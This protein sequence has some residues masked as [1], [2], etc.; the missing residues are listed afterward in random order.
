[1]SPRTPYMGWRDAK[2][3]TRVAILTL[4]DLF[5]SPQKTNSAAEPSLHFDFFFF[6][7]KAF[8]LHTSHVR[9]RFY[10]LNLQG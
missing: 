2:F 8:A 10:A 6:F 9:S 5:N 3:N 7:R 4:G 1:M